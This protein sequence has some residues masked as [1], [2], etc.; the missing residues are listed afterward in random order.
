ME[1]C[2]GEWVTPVTYPVPGSNR[3]E[4]EPVGCLEGCGPN[5]KTMG[6]LESARE[7]C[8]YAAC[9]QSSAVMVD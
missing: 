4:Y 8:A 1:I 7:E 9:S 5:R 2:P 3:G 6:S